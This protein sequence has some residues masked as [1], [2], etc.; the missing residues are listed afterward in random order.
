MRKTE[1]NQLL[2]DRFKSTL[3]TFSKIYVPKHL[4]DSMSKFPYDHH[5]EFCGYFIG[6]VQRK[7]IHV[8]C[9]EW[10]GNLLQDLASNSQICLDY[11]KV[12]RSSRPPSKPF[13]KKLFWWML[14]DRNLHQ[15]ALDALERPSAL[16]NLQK[17][18][19]TAAKESSI[20]SYKTTILGEE[21]WYSEHKKGFL[22]KPEAYYKMHLHS[23]PL[24]NPIL[25]S[26]ADL[27]NMPETSSIAQVETGKAFS[28]CT[29]K[30]SGPGRTIR[31]A[32]FPINITKQVIVILLDK[33]KIIRIEP[34]HDYEYWRSH[35]KL[36]EE[37]VFSMYL[38]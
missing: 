38:I 3:P 17:L 12:A 29:Y 11:L 31:I 8:K 22:T 25:P 6:Q 28:M 32:F 26:S 9:F 14:N 18:I 15:K 13:Q 30:S 36:S 19:H 24:G 2:E 10:C 35:E 37:H 5:F 34:G 21:S 27:C 7:I 20:P 33:P 23:H 4:I 16:E 1:L